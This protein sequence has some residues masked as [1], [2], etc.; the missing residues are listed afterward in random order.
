MSRSISD[1]LEDIL[2]S[3][4]LVKSHVAGLDA[5]EL[6]EISKARDA[7]LFRLAIVCEAATRLPPE[8]PWRK[9]RAMRTY[10]A[11]GYWQIDLVVVVDTIGRDLPVLQAA[12]TRLAAMIERTDV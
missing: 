6:A 5:T 7:T 10:I 1:R 4:D 12:V 3:V 8:I 9:I 2:H 11:H